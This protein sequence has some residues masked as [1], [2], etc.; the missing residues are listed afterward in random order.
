MRRILILPAAVLLTLGVLSGPA[1]AHHQ[2]QLTNPGTD[3][4]DRTV[5]FA[6]EPAAAAQVHPIHSGLHNALDP[7]VM[8]RRGDPG[9]VSLTG[10]AGDCPTDS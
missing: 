2:H 4:L 6:C 7:A 5:V 10:D 3:R 1:L 8:D 9:P